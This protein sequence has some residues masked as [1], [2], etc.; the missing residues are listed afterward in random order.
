MRCGQQYDARRSGALFG[1]R[2]GAVGST[3]NIGCRARFCVPCSRDGRASVLAPVAAP[4]TFG[5]GQD[6]GRPAR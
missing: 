6:R 2:V 4:G 5:L 3:Y 1:A